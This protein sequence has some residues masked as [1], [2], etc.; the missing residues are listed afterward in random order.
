MR[1]HSW[2]KKSIAS[3]LALTMLLGAAPFTVFAADD[4]AAE[5]A[6][7]EQALESRVFEIGGEEYTIEDLEQCAG[8]FMTDGTDNMTI[9]P[10]SEVRTYLLENDTGKFPGGVAQ[11][12]VV[13]TTSTTAQIRAVI[14]SDNLLMSKIEG[15]MYCEM[16][17]SPHTS[18][19]WNPSN[20]VG[21]TTLWQ[22]SSISPATR[23]INR[24]YANFAASRGLNVRAGITSMTV[25]FS[26]GSTAT[27]S[28][29]T[30]TTI[31]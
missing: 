13:S 4:A 30:N 17:A 7:A 18:L 31:Q 12:S 16:S 1:K 23:S 20:G 28:V 9:V 26:N 11:F 2:L 5:Q 24:T 14:T 8:V 22:S 27:G 6:A 25:T 21:T 15:R 3:L 29:Y 10:G 19:F